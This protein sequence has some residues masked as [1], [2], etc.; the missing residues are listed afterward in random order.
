MKLCFNESTSKGCSD[1]EKN[2]RLCA[3]A[4][5]EYIELRFEAHFL[6]IFLNYP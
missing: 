4:G 1:L 3:Q 2:I 5:F 6:I